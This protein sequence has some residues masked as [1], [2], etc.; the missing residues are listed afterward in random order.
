MHSNTLLW[1]WM[2]VSV[3]VTEKQ[4]LRCLTATRMSSEYRPAHDELSPF[5]EDSATITVV[6]DFVKCRSA[7]DYQT[8]SRAASAGRANRQ[9]VRFVGNRKI[10]SFSQLIGSAARRSSLSISGAS[11]QRLIMKAAG[12]YTI[13]I[14]CPACFFRR[15]L[16]VRQRAP[17]QITWNLRSSLSGALN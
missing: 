6:F 4:T 12:L 16:C 3:E 15:A 2:P 5:C 8:A 13:L 11:L 14:P 17:S 10:S 9:K 1:C 7:G